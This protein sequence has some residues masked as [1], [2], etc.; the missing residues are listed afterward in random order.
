MTHGEIT[1]AQ[2]R[3]VLLV[4][5]GP[6]YRPP[7]QRTADGFPFG[8][9][10]ALDISPPPNQKLARQSLS[11]P[12]ARRVVLHW[13]EPGAHGTPPVALHDHLAP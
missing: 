10:R 9:E 4:E 7:R 11:P 1:P 6:A 12:A 5:K 8:E 13:K 2:M 3:D